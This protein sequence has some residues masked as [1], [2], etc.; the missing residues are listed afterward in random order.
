MNKYQIMRDHVRDLLSQEIQAGK[1]QPGDKVGELQVCEALG[2]SRTPAR[3]ALLQLA[4]EGVLEYTPRR[5]FRVKEL[6]QGEKMEVYAAVEVLDALAG[7]LAA[8]HADEA[9]IRS[10]NECVD[11]LDVAIKYR[12]YQDYYSLQ[13]RFHDIYRERCGNSVVRKLLNGLLEGF[14]SHTYSVGDEEELF[15]VFKELNDEHRHIV[16]LFE[17]RDANGVFEFLM[18]THWGTRHSEMI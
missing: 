8:E 2:I 18:K 5:G 11:M 6:A 10:M 7:K 1:L 9:M 17:K 14:V 13:K 4:S 16:S 3:E 12:N 15:T